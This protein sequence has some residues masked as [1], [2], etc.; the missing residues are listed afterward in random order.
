MPLTD[1]QGVIDATRVASESRSPGLIR[2]ESGEVRSATTLADAL[3]TQNLFNQCWAI[4]IATN[5]DDG[6][7]HAAVSFAACL[8]GAIYLAARPGTALA[9]NLSARPDVAITCLGT[10]MDSLMAVGV[11]DVVGA[12]VDQDQSF[13]ESM[14]AAKPTGTFMTSDWPSFI[15][16]FAPHRLWTIVGS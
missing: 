14:N 16:R 15:Y 10:P 1:L 13:R 11:V 12:W 9:H 8:D 3:W 4:T 5:R 6:T 7:P 2:S